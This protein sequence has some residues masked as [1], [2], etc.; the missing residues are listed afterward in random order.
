VYI[1][2]CDAT[3]T[4]MQV[5]FLEVVCMDIGDYTSQIS[6]LVHKMT[7]KAEVDGG[8]SKNP[9]LRRTPLFF[10]LILEKKCIWY[11]GKYG[12]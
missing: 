6:V 9:H 1:K 2:A 8:V 7:I 5:K 12:I 10:T 11:A 4:I 3:T